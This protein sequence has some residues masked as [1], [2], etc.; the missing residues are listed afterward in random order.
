M[1]LLVDIGNTRTKAA[2]VEGEKRSAWP[3]LVTAALTEPDGWRAW[4]AQTTP[5][6][7][8]VSN[9]GGSESARALSDFAHSAW[10]L[11]ARFAEPRR[12]AVGMKTAYANPQQLGVDRWLAAL[13]AWRRSTG[14]VAV[15]DFGTAV[16]L[17]VVTAA[18]LHLGGM[19]APGLELMRRALTE[20]TAD[21]QTQAYAGVDGLAANTN[22][23]ISLGCASALK[24]LLEEMRLR[25]DAVCNEQATRWWLTGG[26]ANTGAEFMTT[27][28]ELEPDLVLLGL[29]EWSA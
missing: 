6:E 25:V 22:D 19:I 4:L 14:A 18:G 12:E 10:G 29:Q 20:K 17:D 9:V 24:G 2:A 15:V 16:T 23:A 1:K 27:A 26:G 21:L 13:A 8:L 7:V 11:E 28:F 5:S 3:A